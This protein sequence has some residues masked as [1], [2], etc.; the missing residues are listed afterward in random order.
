MTGRWT[1]QESEYYMSC[2]II[3]FINRYN[4]ESQPWMLDI[5]GTHQEGQ[6]GH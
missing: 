3:S 4:Q 6:V 2:L 5:G 1:E